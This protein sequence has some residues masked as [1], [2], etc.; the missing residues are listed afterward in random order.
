MQLIPLAGMS[1]NLEDSE[2]ISPLSQSHTHILEVTVSL[3]LITRDDISLRLSC[4]TVRTARATNQHTRHTIPSKLPS[5]A[6]C[7]FSFAFVRHQHSF[8]QAS[9][10]HSHAV[11]FRPTDSSA[12]LF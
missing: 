3:P 5:P 7:Q 9:L 8:L 4:L 12:D 2:L 1:L 11:H 10:V 6:C